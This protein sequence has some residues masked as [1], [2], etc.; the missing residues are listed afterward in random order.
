MINLVLLTLKN[1]K[2]MKK[3]V[4]FITLSILSSLMLI[5]QP[6]TNPLFDY[7]GQ[8]YPNWTDN[9]NWGN[10]I[11]MST[12]A[13]GATNFEKFKNARDELYSQGGGVLYYPGGN[14]TFDI[15]DTHDGEGLM[16]KRGVVIRGDMPGSDIDAITIKDIEAMSPTDNGLNNMPTKFQFNTIVKAGGDVNKMWNMI[17]CKEGVNEASLGEVDYVGVAWI[18]IEHGYIYFG[19]DASKWRARWYYD[20]DGAGY[21]WLGPKSVGTW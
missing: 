21:T 20:D 15:P 16:L 4:L 5:G 10:V 8:N 3:F 11:D 19:F 12:Y 14:Y 9:I 6:M 1:L 17:G 7:Y 2:I 13:N 18:E